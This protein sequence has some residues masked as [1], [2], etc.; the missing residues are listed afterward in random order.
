[1]GF[2]VMLQSIQDTFCFYSTILNG[3]GQFHCAFSGHQSKIF[4]LFPLFHLFHWFLLRTFRREFD[5]PSF[6]V[7]RSKRNDY[8]SIMVF[9]NKNSRRYYVNLVNN[10]RQNYSN[11]QQ[12]K[13]CLKKVDASLENWSKFH[14]LSCKIYNVVKM[15]LMLVLVADKK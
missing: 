15:L 4:P 1:M 10:K 9:I 2:F 7:R 5:L 12:E 6:L 3:T 13:L 14:N 8:Q 11:Y